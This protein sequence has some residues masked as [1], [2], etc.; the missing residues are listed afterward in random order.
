MN[1]LFS[2]ES[3][4]KYEHMTC[5]NTIHQLRIWKEHIQMR[6]S[7]QTCYVISEYHDV[8]DIHHVTHRTLAIDIDQ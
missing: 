6:M 3:K 2:S 8:L 7:I 5:E 4:N 1:D